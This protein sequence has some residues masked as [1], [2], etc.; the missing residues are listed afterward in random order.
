MHTQKLHFNKKK[1][2]IKKLFAL[3][4]ISNAFHTTKDLIAYLKKGILIYDDTFLW[5]F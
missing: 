3:R 4:S 2:M 1:K 5:E